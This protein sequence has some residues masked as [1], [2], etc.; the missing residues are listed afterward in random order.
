[1]QGSRI[2]ESKTSADGTGYFV[3]KILSLNHV[4]YNWLSVTDK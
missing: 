3:T 1:M 4:A 2:L